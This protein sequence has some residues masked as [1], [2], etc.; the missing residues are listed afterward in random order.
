M[1]K[2]GSQ[3]VQI[4]REIIQSPSN[5]IGQK[6]FEEILGVTRANLHNHR[7]AM[8]DGP[9]AFLTRIKNKNHVKGENDSYYY[10][11]KGSVNDIEGISQE[12]Q[13]F[14]E[15]Y[16]HMGYLLDSAIG[17]VPLPES[18]VDDDKV[19][20]LQRKFF[21]LSKVQAKSLDEH[22]TEW[23][24]Q[25]VSALLTNKQISLWYPSPNDPDAGLR[26]EVRPLSLCQY[27]DDLYLLGEEWKH[28]EEKWMLR[29]YKIS[30]I[31]NFEENTTEFTYPSA[32]KWNPSERYKW[33]SG[34]IA[35][36]DG[37]YQEAEIRVYGE[38]RRILQEKFF[39]S[40]RP[41]KNLCTDE[42]DFY[43]FKYT[44]H[45]E[46]IGQLFTY[47]ECVEIVGPKELKD[48]FIKKA[49]AA[50]G[51]NVPP[52]APDSYQVSEKKRAK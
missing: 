50:L 38:F 1:S 44:N 41:E 48:A 43:V 19:K 23:L 39:M 11:L 40:A 45:N 46:F 47:A 15:A 34:L 13:Y 29:S 52:D 27:R 5:R 36:E 24:K 22:Q 42:Y 4:I 8:C 35:R 28:L 9:D 18:E 16:K 21:Y 2:K 20:E 25:I 31:D 49:A 30:R 33:T 3:Y 6:R 26:R 51:K 32:S 10:V 37:S 7:V 14:L 17:D 12:T